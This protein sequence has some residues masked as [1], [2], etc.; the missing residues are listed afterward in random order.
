VKKIKITYKTKSVP[1][2]E[3]QRKINSAF[4]ALFNTI[5]NKRKDN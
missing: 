1:P 5:F 2:E 4:D 3:L